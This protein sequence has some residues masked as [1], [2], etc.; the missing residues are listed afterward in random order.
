MN[1][2]LTY[3]SFEF[4]L[5]RRLFSEIMGSV[6]FFISLIF[7]IPFSLDFDSLLHNKIKTS[8]ILS[9]FFLVQIFSFPRIFQE[10]F[11][12]GFLDFL[13]LA[14][15]VSLEGVIFVKSF[16]HMCVIG[17]STLLLA[18]FLLFIQGIPLVFLWRYCGI[19]LLLA[20]LISLM[21]IFMGALTLQ[22]RTNLPLFAILIFPFFIPCLILG[23]A[24]FQKIMLGLPIY[25]ESLALL[26]LLMIYIPLSIF[27]GAFALRESLSA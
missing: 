22:A 11:K 18:L 4:K 6:L 27:G 20:P 21:G 13:A 14:R 10:D 19:F 12:E 2:I 9:S 7:L 8:L 5:Q 15:G 25:G 1:K 17:F 3:C 26:G 24:A 16:V 23:A